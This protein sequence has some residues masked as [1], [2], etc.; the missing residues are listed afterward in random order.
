LGGSGRDCFYLALRP[1]SR[2]RGLVEQIESRTLPLCSETAM[3]ALAEIDLH[4]KLPR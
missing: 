4:K 3:L 2:D 1:F